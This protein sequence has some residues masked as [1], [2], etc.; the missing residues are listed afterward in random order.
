M[1]SLIGNVYDNFPLSRFVSI[2]IPIE[3]TQAEIWKVLTKP[4]YSRTLQKIFGLENTLNE[5][6][7]LSSEVNFKYL[8]DTLITSSFG[9]NHFGNQYI[10][11]DF[12]LGDY[13]Y[14]EKFLLED[15]V[16]KHTEL[17][18][19]CGPYRDDF[20]SQKFILNNWALKVVELSEQ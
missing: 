17:K 4:E 8:N 3:A 9:G 18:I 7:N 2:S 16:T 10:Q 12:K 20:E 1:T 6:W 5:N 11:I 19:V 14:V 13:K 15:A